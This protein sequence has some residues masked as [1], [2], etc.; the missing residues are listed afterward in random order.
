MA[1]DSKGKGAF[2]EDFDYWR[3][4]DELS[5]IQAAFLTVGIDPSSET[6]TYCEGWKPHERP[7]GYE[8]AKAAI[9]R[10]LMSNT[11]TGGLVQI[12]E[13]DINGNACGFVPG[14]IDISVSWIDVESLRKWLSIR[15]LTTGFFFPKRP[16]TADYLD[17]RNPRYAP[18]LAAAVRAWQSVADPKGKTPKQALQK[19]LRE[20]AVEFGLVD[21]EGKLNETAVEE[22]SKVANWK[23]EG[24]PGKTPGA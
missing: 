5:V 22:I 24:G 10:A 3:M 12:A 15:G 21:D 9:S 8:A 2:V 16:E 7:A 4:C 19:W 11:I 17:E 20:H 23:P 13:H 14:S 18:K 6:G 1:S